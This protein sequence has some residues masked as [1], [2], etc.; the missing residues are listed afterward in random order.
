MRYATNAASGGPWEA[1]T[2]PGSLRAVGREPDRSGSPEGPGRLRLSVRRGLELATHRDIDHAIVDL[3]RQGIRGQGEIGRLVGRD[4][5]SVSR[6]IARLVRIGA[7]PFGDRPARG[8]VQVP[9]AA[10]FIAMPI[11]R[12]FPAGEPSLSLT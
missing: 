7:W 4:Q 1:P 8:R 9:V 3:W 5:R 12:S 2:R 11:A 10:G 6:R